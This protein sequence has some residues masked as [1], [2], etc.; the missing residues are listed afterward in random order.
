VLQVVESRSAMKSDEHD[1]ANC[2]DGTNTVRSRIVLCETLG[3]A[4]GNLFEGDQVEVNFL[5]RP[6]G[7]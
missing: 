7:L 6:V 3:L 2:T 4:R 1:A 5:F